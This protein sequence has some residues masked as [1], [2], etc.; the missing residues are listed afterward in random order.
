MKKNDRISSY[1]N[2]LVVS[3]KLADASCDARYLGYFICFNRGDYYEAHDVLEDLWLRT[4]GPEYAFYKGLIQIAGA[5]VHLR[6]HYEHPTHPKHSRRL[7]PATRLFD[8]GIQNIAP[9]LPIH[10]QLAVAAVIRLCQT[11]RDAIIAADFQVNPWSP[12][13]LPMLNLEN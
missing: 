2:E 9:F 5:F 6:K 11:T 3:H 1:V 13:L 8:L 12:D 10:D 4:T 7:R